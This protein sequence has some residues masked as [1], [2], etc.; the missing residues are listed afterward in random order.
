[1]GERR[2][3][4]SV[5]KSRLRCTE[6]VPSILGNR[7]D[8]AWRELACARAT[9]ACAAATDVER[10]RTRASACCQVLRICGGV[11]TGANMG[12]LMSGMP[13][14]AGLA[15]VEGAALPGKEPVAELP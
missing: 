2:P 12:S 14:A 1:E 9:R 4:P 3:A 13:L 11:S 7:P 6:P 15:A 5:P 10:A 8:S